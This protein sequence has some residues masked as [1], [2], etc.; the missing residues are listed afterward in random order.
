MTDLQDKSR[1][2]PLE[3][4]ADY[5]RNPLFRE[6][7]SEIQ[8]EYG[9]AEKVEFSACSLEPGWN[10]KFKK[11]GRTLC[12]VYPRE[13]YFTVLVVVGRRE[14]EPVEAM[15]PGCTPEFRGI[16][17]RTKEGGG[18]RWLMADLEDRDGLYRDVLRTIGI[19]RGRRA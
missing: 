15:L 11:A 12:T 8:A 1:C 7:C 16:Y 14:K 4:I 19:R 18:Q 10:V 9:C 5:V 17:A 6:F 3:E 2:P 13:D